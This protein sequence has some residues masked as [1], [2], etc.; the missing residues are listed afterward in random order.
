MT[1]KNVCT[2]M[3]LKFVC[4]NSRRVYHNFID[5]CVGHGQ[6]WS[7]NIDLNHAKKETR[8]LF[9]PTVECTL[10][11]H[12]TNTTVFLTTNLS[13]YEIPKI[14]PK[15]MVTFAFSNVTFFFPS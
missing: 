4:P 13:M 9:E 5:D 7:E 3:F 10:T 1:G 8:N 15:Y 2:K 12:N 14:T 6:K 11:K